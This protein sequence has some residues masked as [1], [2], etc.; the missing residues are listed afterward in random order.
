MST[1]TPPNFKRE[2]AL[3]KEGYSRIVGVDEVGCGALAGPVVA[4]AVILPLDSRLGAIRDSK[5]LSESARE[6][7]YEKIIDKSVAWGVG[8]AHVEEIMKYNIRGAN[9]LAMRRAVECIDDVEY[10]LVDA[11]T[12]PDIPYPQ[13]S[14]IKG[15]RKVKSIA[16]ASIVAKV[17]RDNYMK[18]LAN[19]FPAYGFDQHKGYGTRLHRQAITEHGACPQHR[20]TFKTFL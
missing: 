14:V 2:R 12:I 9:L 5:L 13:L 4:A 16:A 20:L 11:W 6:A 18:K 1:K 3:Y 10:V 17:V 15:D 19:Q 7:L 8:M